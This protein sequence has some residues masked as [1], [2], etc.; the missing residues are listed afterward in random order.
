M[1]YKLSYFNKGYPQGDE[2]CKLRPFKRKRDN[3]INPIRA[4]R[5]HD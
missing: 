3:L 5:Q 4:Q 1:L 2:A